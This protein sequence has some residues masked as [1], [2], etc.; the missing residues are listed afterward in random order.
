MFFFFALPDSKEIQSLSDG[1]QS[2]VKSYYFTSGESPWESNL[3]GDGDD[4][5]DEEDNENEELEPSNI[6]KTKETVRC[7]F[8]HYIIL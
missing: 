7:H 5:K 3:K 2:T 4:F 1:L 8:F 6:S